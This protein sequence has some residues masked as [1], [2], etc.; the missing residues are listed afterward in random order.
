VLDPRGEIYERVDQVTQPYGRLVKL[1]REVQGG[2]GDVLRLSTVRTPCW[3]AHVDAEGEHGRDVVE[4]MKEYLG[5]RH[6][7]LWPVHEPLIPVLF[8][9]QAMRE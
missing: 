4:P 9:A 6:R 5:R 8:F 2:Y 1:G 7:A 3:V